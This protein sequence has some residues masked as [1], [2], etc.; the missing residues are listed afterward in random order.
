[1]SIIEAITVPK[2]GLT[3]TEGTLTEWLVEEGDT[4]AVGDVVADMETSK[5]V[6][7]V[8]SSVAGVV[9]RLVA[10]PGET[11]D[12]AQLLAV[13][14]AEDTPDA[15]IDAYIA[16]FEPEEV[17]RA[18][19][20]GDSSDEETDIATAD[21][22]AAEIDTIP[23]PEAQA[24]G[25]LSEG[26]DDSDVH[27]SR[28]A[29]KLAGEYNVNLNNVSPSGR[30]SRIS[31]ADVIS[32]IESAGGHVTKPAVNRDELST[33][34]SNLD[35]SHIKVTSVAARLAKKLGI[36][37]NDCRAS[38][39][40]GRVCKADVEAANAL[41][42]GQASG[43]TKALGSNTTSEISAQVDAVF[44]DV[45]MTG[46]RKT[47]AARLQE[48]KREAPHFRLSIDCCLDQLLALRAQINAEEPGVKL[49]VNDFVIKAT[50]MAL[51]KSPDVNV[52]FDGETIRRFKHADVSVAVALENGLITPILKRAE[53]LSLAQVSNEMRSL[54][55][56]AKA[57][58]LKP[59]EFI[60]GTFSVSNL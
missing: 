45:P 34:R 11:M 17:A 41:L 35:D 19:L 38:G 54:A 33:H 12:I 42:N 32:A 1:M 47:I 22:A 30:N 49:S 44:D 9:R 24:L 26:G 46:M 59:E 16:D 4:V 20:L 5:I 29:R 39:N 58:T 57:G 28:Y 15:V 60:G 55:T 56:R 37:L 2:W 50:A 13:V 25:A 8:E 18:D 3:M 40:R 53:T 7:Q 43:R 14:A 21:S 48:S 6:N 23:A 31:K 36:N 52:Q 51:S 10:Q 27:A